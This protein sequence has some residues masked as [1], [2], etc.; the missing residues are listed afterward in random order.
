[1]ARTPCNIKRTGASAGPLIW[2]VQQLAARWGVS[3]EQ[4]GNFIDAGNLASI[5]CG[6]GAV[7]KSW[8]IPIEAVAHFERVN[9]SLFDPATGKIHPARPVRQKGR[10]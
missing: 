3:S 5:N 6:V 9:S 2:R 4:V 7:R 8:R 10:R 1:M